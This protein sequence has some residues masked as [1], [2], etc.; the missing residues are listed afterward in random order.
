MATLVLTIFHCFEDHGLSDENDKL[1]ELT[2]LQ[3]IQP[4]K[5][6]LPEQAI[7]VSSIHSQHFQLL[8]A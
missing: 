4:A 1:P 8:A 7:Q 3:L 2:K 5:T 6:E